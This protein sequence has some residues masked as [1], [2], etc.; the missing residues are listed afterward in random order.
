MRHRVAE[1]L[2]MFRD[3]LRAVDVGHAVAFKFYGPAYEPRR[4][5]FG[6]DVGH[7]GEHASAK[8]ED[9]G[10][11]SD[12]NGVEMLRTYQ[13]LHFLKSFGGFLRCEQNNILIHDR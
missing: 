1:R 7:A 2:Q 8:I 10:V 6:G 11:V 12:Q 3:V 4:L 13:G 9:I 5:A